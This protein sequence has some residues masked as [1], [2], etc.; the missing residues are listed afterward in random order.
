M[1]KKHEVSTFHLYREKKGREKVEI[2]AKGLPAIILAAKSNPQVLGTCCSRRAHGT[3]FGGFIKLIKIVSS[4]FKSLSGPSQD[5]YFFGKNGIQ[6]LCIIWN[7]RYKNFAASAW[8][9]VI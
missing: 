4:I 5:N 7:K 2:E 8:F 6:F 1:E 3:V 9:Q